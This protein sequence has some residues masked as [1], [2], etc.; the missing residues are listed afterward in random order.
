MS[1]STDKET[2]PYSKLKQFVPGYTGF[3]KK[4]YFIAVLLIYNVVLVSGVQPCGP[5]YE[6][7][8]VCVCVCVCVYIL[9]NILF[10]YGLL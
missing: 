7:I 1:I 5:V 10:Q 8:C 9:L 4:N 6:Y 2:K 3:L